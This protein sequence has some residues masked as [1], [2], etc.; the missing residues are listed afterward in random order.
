MIGLYSR[1]KDSYVLK[2]TSEILMK[3]LME[4]SNMTCS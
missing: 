4:V 1:L 2:V 3:Y